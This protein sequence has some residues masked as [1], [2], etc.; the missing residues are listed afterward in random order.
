MIANLRISATGRSMLATRNNERAAAAAGVNVA[1]VKMLAFAISAFI[2]GVGGAL[3]AYRSG[4]VTT[5]KFT[6]LQ[7][8][9]FMA[10]AYIGGISSV[11]GAIAGGMLVS[12]G[13]F[14]TFLTNILHVPSEFT[15]ILGGLGL[16]FASI[17]NPEGLSGSLRQRKLRISQ[18][19]TA[20]NRGSDEL[21]SP[22]GKEVGV[23]S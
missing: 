22:V 9:T 12:G 21:V 2:A 14:F 7:S 13:I 6:F 17:Q 11:S 23:D 20:R 4:G 8:L 1:G 10:F 5:D 19:L 18:I 16:I 15:L 3:I